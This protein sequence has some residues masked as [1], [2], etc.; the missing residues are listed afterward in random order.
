MRLW[1]ARL[2]GLKEFER[3]R[4]EMAVLLAKMDQVHAEIM[5]ARCPRCGARMF[6]A[7]DPQNN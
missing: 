1:L 3:V 7:N 5:D 6:D 4:N 2:L